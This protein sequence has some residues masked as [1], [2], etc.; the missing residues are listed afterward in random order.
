MANKTTREEIE[1]FVKEALTQANNDR[2]ECMD[3]RYT[4]EQSEGAVR[5]P[6]GDLGM[7]MAFAGALKDEGTSLTPEEIVERY[8]K[9]VSKKR[10]EKPKLYYHD[11]D[12]SHPIGCGHVAR[13][14]SPE[15]DGLYG[16]LTSQDVRQLYEAFVVHPQAHKTVLEGPHAEKAVIFVHGESNEGPIPYTINS[17]DAKGNMYFVVDIDRANRFIEKAA[18]HFSEGLVNTV[19]A[20]DVKRNFLIQLNATAGLLAGDKDKFKVTV[21]QDGSFSMHQLPKIEPERLNQ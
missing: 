19:K 12:S 3:G 10:G 5:A 4:S 2:I 13:A 20:E 16:S 17:S 15:F 8:S 14:S 18:L 9:S 6:G 1:E 11:D 21:G 7:V